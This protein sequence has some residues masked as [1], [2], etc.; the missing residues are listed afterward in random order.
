MACDFVILDTTFII[1]LLRGKNLE[2]KE[3]AEELDHLFETKAVVSVSVNLVPSALI[4]F[5]LVIF[6]CNAILFIYP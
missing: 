3:K 1:D 5:V 6:S 4:L 2:V